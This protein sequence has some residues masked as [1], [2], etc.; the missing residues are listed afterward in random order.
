MSILDRFRRGG[1]ISTNAS[2]RLTQEGKEKLQDFRG[3]DK[4]RILVALETEGSSTIAEIAS[5]SG[6]NKGK[7]ERLLPAMVRAGYIQYVSGTT[8]GI[9]DE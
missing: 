4:S 9:A 7:V 3:D 5:A 2:F 8:G 6:L 1:G